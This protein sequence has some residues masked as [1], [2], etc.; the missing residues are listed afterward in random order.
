MTYP[1]NW[2]CPNCKK[3]NKDSKICSNCKFKYD[4]HYPS[5]WHC[6]NCGNKIESSTNC[7]KCGYPDQLHYP[8]LWHC[9]S[10][11]KLIKSST[12]CP[13][14]IK[15]KKKRQIAYKISKKILIPLILSLLILTSLMNL[16]NINKLEKN[17]DYTVN[18][19]QS[20]ITFPAWTVIEFINN[21]KLT[22][23]NSE[24]LISINYFI[25]DKI[26]SSTRS[27]IN[28]LY[29]QLR[30]VEIMQEYNFDNWEIMCFNNTNYYA[31]LGATNCNDKI[32]FLQ[33]TDYNFNPTNDYLNN[34]IST[35]CCN[36]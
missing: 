7:K 17:N 2:K 32:L 27:E 4:L 12:K 16:S 31:C 25:N 6:P 3:E 9:D 13:Y 19:S 34:L 20:S 1:E 11:N 29:S 24:E 14:C 26:F 23:Y 33:I 35:F 15:P 21:S 22:L 5:L 30:E 8:S 28:N 10:C 18:F 36:C